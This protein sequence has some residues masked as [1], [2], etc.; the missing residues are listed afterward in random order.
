MKIFIRKWYKTIGT[1]LSLIFNSFGLILSIVGI[2]TNGNKDVS[3]TIVFFVLLAAEIF[4]ILSI[5]YSIFSVFND[6][7]KL[8]KVNEKINEILKEKR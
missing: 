3:T 1:T 7:S 2:I 5:I 6:K 8:I 4:L